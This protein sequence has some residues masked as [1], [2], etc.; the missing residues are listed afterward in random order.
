MTLDLSLYLVTDAASAASAGHDVVDVVTAAVAGGVTAVQIREKDASARAFL[1]TVERIAA[2]TP[3]EVAVFV[4]D[5]VDVFLAARDR[6]ARVAGVHVGQSDLPAGAVRALVGAHAFVGLS[7]ATVA[8]LDIERAAP[9]VDYVG[10]GAVH[11]TRTKSDAPPALGIEG[12][13]HL[14]ALAPVPAV[15]IGGIQAA[16]LGPLRAAGAAGA[17]VV[18]AIC[19]ANDPREAARTLRAAWE[20]QS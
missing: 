17:A 1:E 12:F 19:A 14:A 13:A 6:G 15:A 3:P 5:R 8:E 2:A 11:P 16:D 18:S 20:G 9:V 10:I 7:A 4:N